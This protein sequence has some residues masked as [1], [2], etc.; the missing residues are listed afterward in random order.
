[1]FEGDNHMAADNY[2]RGEFNIDNLTSRLVGKTM[3]RV[4]MNLD[5][6]G[7]LHCLA[8]DLVTTSN[9]DGIS[10]WFPLDVDI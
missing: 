2:K 4:E 7:D 8:T 3:I 10:V 5:E 6:S 9:R 1:M